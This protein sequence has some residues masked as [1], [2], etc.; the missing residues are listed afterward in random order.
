MRG[1]EGEVEEE[2]V[3]RVTL[4][5][6]DRLA[7]E[8]VRQVRLLRH[9]FRAAQ[10]L[11]VEGRAPFGDPSEIKANAPVI[12]PDDDG[13]ARPEAV[14]AP[15][16]AEELVEAPL[17]RVVLGRNAEVPLA[18]RA[19]HVARRLQAVREGGLLEGEGIVGCVFVT[20]H[21]KTLLVPPGQQP[22]ARRTAPG[23][24][25]VPVR[26]P[27][28]A[29][30][31]GVEVRRRDVLDAL[32]PEVPVA[33]VVRDDQQDV[34][35]AVRRRRGSRRAA[36]RDGRQSEA[37][38]VGSGRREHRHGLAP[39]GW[40]ASARSSRS[41]APGVRRRARAPGR[42]GPRSRRR[43][44]PGCRAGTESPGRAGHPAE[45]RPHRTPPGR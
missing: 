21:A 29:G 41:S 12:R 16:E 34:G 33:E 10:D 28:P 6:R 2:R 9:R 4:D 31:E 44:R 45:C 17:H 22:R 14:P 19:G 37:C 24:G 43:P 7:P 26:E 42:K 3:R 23:P 35:L 27:H 8:R 36:Q 25:H 32:E 18:H 13:N 39:T 15:H 20:M 11:P 38:R 30:R 5:E 1:V 40:G